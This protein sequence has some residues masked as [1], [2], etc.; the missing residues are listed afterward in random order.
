VQIGDRRL[1][2]HCII[3]AHPEIIG[4][5]RNPLRKRLDA[6]HVGS[7]RSVARLA[8]RAS[9]SSSR[10]R[11]ACRSS[12]RCSTNLSNVPRCRQR[13]IRLAATRVRR[14]AGQGCTAFCVRSA[15]SRRRRSRPRRP[16]ATSST[17]HSADVSARRST[18]AVGPVGR[19]ID[20]CRRWRGCGASSRGSSPRAFSRLASACLATGR[21]ATRDGR[22]SSPRCSNA[23]RRSRRWPARRLRRPRR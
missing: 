21:T 12:W 8:V 15:A 4:A 7:S 16:R 11:S 23:S 6:L 14:A 10:S 19:R 17:P 13:V 3:R 2:H 22:P 9:V 5:G 18:G 1:G 20:C